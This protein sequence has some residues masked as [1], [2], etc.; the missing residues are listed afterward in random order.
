MEL[1]T[2]TIE[3]QPLIKEIHKNEKEH[4]GSF[5]LYQVWDKFIRGERIPYTYVVVEGKG[6]CRYG[7]SKKYNHYVIHEVGVLPEYKRQGISRFILE[8]VP[9]PLML[10][11]NVDNKIGN[12]FY[13]KVGMVLS[14]KT[15]T[16]NGVKQNIWTI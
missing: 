12:E 3:D 15:Q 7:F 13:K 11:C 4:L 2:A 14:G 8:N 5:N 9:R 10:K 6:F 16:K 1:R